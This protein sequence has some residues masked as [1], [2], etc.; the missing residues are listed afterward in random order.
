MNR[1]VVLLAVI[2]FAAPLAAL[3]RGGDADPSPTR[4]V[5]PPAMLSLAPG[6]S[7][8][9]APRPEA[10]AFQMPG[11]DQEY[12]E[13]ARLA[14]RYVDSQFQSA[15]GLVNSVYG[16]PYATLWDVASGLAALY[17]ASELGLLPSE[18]YDRR[19]RL[20]LRTLV[21]VRL[22]DEAAFSK[23]YNVARAVP[24]GSNDRQMA[25]RRDG[26]GWSATDLGR[27]LVWLRII[28][29]A[30]PEYEPLARAV[31]ARIDFD[32][33]IRDGYLWGAAANRGGGARSYQEGRLGYEQY[34]A[35]GFAL[36]DQNA[37]RALN[38]M[39]NAREERVYGVPVWVDRRG[40][41]HLTSE[42]FFLMGL[43]LG[44]WDPLWKEQA[45]RVLAAQRARYERTG[46]VTMVSEDA[47]PVPPFYFYYYTIFDDG[48][49]FAVRA[50]GSR[51]PDPEPR[52]VSA[53]AAFA[54][55]A[56]MP[57]EYT[58]LALQEVADRAAHPRL[59]WSS[60]VYE[61]SR[62]ATGSQN[63]NTAAVILE[64]ALYH[65]RRRPLLSAAAAP[66]I[67]SRTAQ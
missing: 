52:W 54:W 34:A 39:Q 18:E 38:L 66:P 47:V 53:K 27:L 45:E 5:R 10:P 63:I 56:L 2:F 42:P 11:E 9:A 50:L 43:E 37:D 46:R 31:V 16:Y 64:S 59:G 60:G 22:F 32:R 65:A 19:M 62:R 29:V 3:L 57:G 51:V 7:A 23:N 44:W 15:T 61:G 40:D 13:A 49:P 41:G 36:W 21:S 26:Y 58:W 24:A 6:D 8:P 67:A 20:A 35:A 33:V 12:L 28:A 48:E 14:W 4:L 30:H 25:V 55:Y 17:A 1:F